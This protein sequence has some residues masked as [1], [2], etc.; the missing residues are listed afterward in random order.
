MI[1]RRTFLQKSALFGASIASAP[2]LS[3]FNLKN[4]YDTADLH[5]HRSQELTVER[6]MEISQARQV[7]FGVVEH[8]G[9]YFA[10]KN[11]NDLKL[12]I[13][14]MR[15]L[16]FRVGLQPVSVG[17]SKDFSREL[18]G[19]LDYILMDGLAVPNQTKG[20]DH[21]WMLQTHVADS[22]EFMKRYIDNCLNI[23]ENEPLDIF[24]WPLFLPVC[25]ARHYDSLW[26]PERKLQILQVAHKRNIALELNDMAH[27]PDDEFIRQGKSMGLKFT[28][29]SDSRNPDSA[30][31]LIFCR[32]TAARC[33]LNKEDFFLPVKKV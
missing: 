21:I 33:Q 26:T 11:D 13:Q 23:L 9:K 10:I 6:M 32:E 29:G 2:W 28:F 27:T 16:P 7:D 4:N 5:V 17:W 20:F 12:Y 3:G 22:E 1:N 25:I 8:P 30:G 31:R 15:K 24:A 14:N 19:Q 18:L